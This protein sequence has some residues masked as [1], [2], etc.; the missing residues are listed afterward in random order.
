MASFDPQSVLDA[1]G[2][3]ADGRAALALEG[4]RVAVV[5]GFVRDSLLGRDPRELDLVIEGDLRS[6]AL[7]LGGEVR[8]HPQFLAVHVANDGWAMEITHARSERYAR[9]GALPSVEP[10]TIEEDLRGAT[11]ASTRSL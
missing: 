6:I 5:G 11:S 10:A 3:R 4:A 9:P 7:Q 2:A 1:L 8:E